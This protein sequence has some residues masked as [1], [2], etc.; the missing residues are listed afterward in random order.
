MNPIIPHLT[1]VFL[2]F[3][4]PQTL[5]KR[6][7]ISPVAFRP[8][9]GITNPKLANVLSSQG[10][11]CVTFTCR[12]FDCG[13]RCISG[14]SG[15]ILRKV[16]PDDIILFHDVRPKGAVGAEGF[17]CEIDLILRGLSNKGL[18]VVP[19]AELQGRPV[20]VRINGG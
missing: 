20:M 14:M 5:L 11:T 10:L 17:L 13:N 15:K 18:Q 3:L 2:E 19:L 12:A 9:V 4:M 8:P 16:K 1:M 7:G 6:F